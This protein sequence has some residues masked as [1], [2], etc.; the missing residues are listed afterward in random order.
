MMTGPWSGLVKA[1]WFAGPAGLDLSRIRRCY[2]ES[3]YRRVYHGADRPGGFHR[4]GVVEH[5]DYL[6]RKVGSRGDVHRRLLV[7]DL[8]IVLEDAEVVGDD[9]FGNRPALGVLQAK[10]QRNDE[11]DS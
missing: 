1:R 2:Y 10:I 7:V 4:L 6:V 3:G 11:G 8:E 5:E 9:P